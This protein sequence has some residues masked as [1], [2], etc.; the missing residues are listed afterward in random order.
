[1]KQPLLVLSFL[2]A[3]SISLVAN[4]APAVDG[5]TGLIAVPSADTLREGQFS[6]GYY[7]LEDGGT[8]SFNM[9]LKNQLEVGV[10]GFHYGNN[11]DNDYFLNAKFSI[12]PETVLTPGLAVGVMDVADKK[13]RTA[14]AVVSKA[15]PF[16][17]RLHAGVG[18]GR[19]DGGFAAIEKT[20]N[21]LHILTGNNVFPATTLMAEYDG[22]KFNYGARMS[23]LPGLKLDAGRRH[24]TTYFGI[25]FTN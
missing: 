25:S 4:A 9:S 13:E 23:V 10:A 21:P 5:P 8:G 14:Y 2:V 3:F 6:L 12:F 7:K 1:M 16:G 11:L 18:N 15:L 17:F 19:Y 24:D 22:K 20:I